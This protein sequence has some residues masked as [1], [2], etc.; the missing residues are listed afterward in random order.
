MKRNPATI[1]TAVIIGIIFLSMLFTFQVRQTQIAVVTT[2]G[3]F[4]R[5]INEPGLQFRWP[6]PIQTVYKFD[7]R[8]RNFEKKYEE[9]TTKDGRIIIIQAFVGWRVKDGR[10]FLERFGGDSKRAEQTLEALL[11]DAKNT[12]VGRHPFSDFISPDPKKVKFDQI[13][14]EML[15]LIKPRAAQ[16]YGIDV[17]LVGIKQIGLPESITTKVFDRMKA[18][19]QELVRQYRA[20]GEAEARKI[21]SEADRRRTEILAEAESTATIIEGQAEAQATEALRTFEKNPQLASFLLKLRALEKAL[22]QRSTLVL[23]PRTPP[24]DLLRG[25][26]LSGPPLYNPTEIRTN[27]IGAV[28]KALEEEAN[29]TLSTNSTGRAVQPQ[30]KER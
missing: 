23:D 30:R 8:I 22:K 2:F 12:V 20:E 25:N 15:D 13:E 18:E 29:Q 17:V 10:L 4:T 16:A 14:K 24:F 28:K 7:R 1:F 3:K 27:V 21:R 19:R 11:R 5:Q 9:T 6:W 26:R